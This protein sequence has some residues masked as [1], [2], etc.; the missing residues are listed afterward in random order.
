MLLEILFEIVGAV[1]DFLGEL[2]LEVLFHS[3][4]GLTKVV[5]ETF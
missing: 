5:R 1:C 2:I 3:L 4:V